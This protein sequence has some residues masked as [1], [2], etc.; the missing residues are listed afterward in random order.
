M[1]TSFCLNPFLVVILAAAA[2]RLCVYDF[3]FQM[4]KILQWLKSLGDN[5]NVFKYVYGCRYLNDGTETTHKTCNL[6]WSLRA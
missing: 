5:N 6:I 2:E 1:R 4:S 3:D